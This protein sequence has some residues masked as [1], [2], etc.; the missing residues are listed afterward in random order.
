M[1]HADAEEEEEEEADIE[2]RGVL[3]NRAYSILF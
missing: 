3:S 1:E 2:W